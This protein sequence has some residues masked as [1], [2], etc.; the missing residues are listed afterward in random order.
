M[1]D[2]QLI[3]FSFQVSS[4]KK[5]YLRAKAFFFFPT[6]FT[7][8]ALTSVSYRN[9]VQPLDFAAAGALSGAI[10][11]TMLGPKA[12]AAAAL[13]GGFFGLILGSFTWLGFKIRGLTVPEYR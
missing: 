2:F 11:K 8:L 13:G 9:Y 1:N 6:F 12:Q 7:A 5:G 3:I 10:W 4:L